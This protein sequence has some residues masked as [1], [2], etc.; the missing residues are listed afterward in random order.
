MFSV[1]VEKLDPKTV[2]DASVAELER[3]K[4]ELESE[5][6]RMELA[7]FGKP[8]ADILEPWRSVAVEIFSLRQ[9][10]STS[11]LHSQ[12]STGTGRPSKG[13]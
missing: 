2:E 11:P 5:L 4:L 3:Q 1:S 13:R 8:S 9:L 6:T 12:R 7:A 10:R